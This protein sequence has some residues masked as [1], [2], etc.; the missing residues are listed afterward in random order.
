MNYAPNVPASLKS[1]RKKHV[2]RSALDKEAVLDF[3]YE[4]L[5]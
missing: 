3:F 4:K 2:N 1:F 5:S